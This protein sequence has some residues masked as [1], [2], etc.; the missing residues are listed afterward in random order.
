V[1]AAG[2]SAK[3]AEKVAARILE[4]VVRPMII[5]ELQ[6][7]SSASIGVFSGTPESSTAEDLL[8][9]A[10]L[11]LYRAKELGKNRWHLFTPDLRTRARAR[12]ALIHDL[13]YALERDELRTYYQPKFNLETRQIVGF[14][15]LLRWQH[16]V[17][18]LVAPNDFIPLAEETGLIVPIGEWI[19]REACR[20][21]H[22]WDTRFL[23]LRLNMNVNL[24]VHQLIDPDVV[25]RVRLIIEESSIAPTSLNLELTETAL[26]TNLESARSV[27]SELRTLRVGL[28]LDDFGTGYSSLGYLTALHFDSLKIDR[29]FV[30]RMTCDHECHAIVESITG[31]ARALGMT[32]VAE[33][34]ERE[35]H[36]HELLRLGCQIGQGFYFSP[37]VP[38]A[39]AT[40]MIATERSSCKLAS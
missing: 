5:D 33:G 36:V 31:L 18:G 22:A 3:D 29:G 34:V 40:E 13:R 27:L 16:P 14:E 11:A 28:K 10:H 19:L 15:A 37:A 7:S 17:R 30:S 35:E 2:V 26:M 32:L 9:D 8:R 20:Q 4:A 39:A 21:L 25:D 6:V 38:A 12:L 23:A 24:S 1:L